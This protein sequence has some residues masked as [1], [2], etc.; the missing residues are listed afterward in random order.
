MTVLILTVW[1]RLS[2]CLLSK[3]KGRKKSKTKPNALFIPT[4]KF[5]FQKPPSYAR[6][7]LSRFIPSLNG[8]APRSPPSTN[9]AAPLARP[10]PGCRLLL[11]RR[12]SLARGVCAAATYY[13]TKKLLDVSCKYPTTVRVIAYKVIFKW[14]FKHP[15]NGFGCLL[16]GHVTPPE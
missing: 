16:A 3:E 14:S 2:H 5:T 12:A 10:S 11:S 6:E 9:P 4:N 15:H 13:Q 7:H 1:P 8:T